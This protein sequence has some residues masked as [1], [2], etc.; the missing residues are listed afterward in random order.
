MQNII[1][2]N[3]S[4]DALTNLSQ[5]RADY[6][7]TVATLLRQ[8]AEELRDARTNG[9]AAELT[10]AGTGSTMFA[11][12]QAALNAVSDALFY[13]D[14]DTKD[15]KLAIPVGLSQ[16]DSDVCP[17]ALESRYAKIS[18]EAILANLQAF[19][20]LFTGGEGLGFDDWLDTVGAEALRKTMLKDVDAAIGLLGSIEEPT[21]AEAL[22]KDRKSV[23]DVY[24]AVK[25]VS[26]NLKSQF[27]GVLDLD[28]PK[29]V[30]GD[31][32]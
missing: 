30:E 25:A 29:S 31:N 26:D 13:L 28:L 17:N 8:R 27:I 16:C 12:P 4:W 9:F 5:A 3:G 14:K 6:A 24:F 1:N 23:E 7:H 2:S 19:R 21:L 22:G 18:K 11:S 32:D 15:M 10:A 20:L